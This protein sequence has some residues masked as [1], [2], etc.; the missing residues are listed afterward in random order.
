MNPTPLQMR[1]KWLRL[2]IVMSKDI[3]KRSYIPREYQDLRKFKGFLS[4]QVMLNWPGLIG[5]YGLQS[6]N[7]TRYDIVLRFL[8]VPP[9]PYTPAETVIKKAHELFN[10]EVCDEVEFIDYGDP[11]V[12]MVPRQEDLRFGKPFGVLPPE[13]ACLYT[14]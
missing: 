6:Q 7:T 12:D 3:T 8:S 11:S 13:L 2:S 9:M 10:G 4:Y 5:W 14:E 1:E